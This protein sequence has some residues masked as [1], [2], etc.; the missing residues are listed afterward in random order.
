MA[1]S[2]FKMCNMMSLIKHNETGENLTSQD[3]SRI[4]RGAMLSVVNWP[5]E[6]SFTDNAQ[7]A[8]AF[9]PQPRHHHIGSP[10][11]SASRTPQPSAFRSA[12]SLPLTPTR[13]T[14]HVKILNFG[15]YKGKTYDT[16][17]RDASY[18]NWVL[19]ELTEDL[20][21]GRYFEDRRISER[22]G[23]AFIATKVIKLSDSEDA[24]TLKKAPLPQRMT[25]L[26]SWTPAATRLAMVN[27]G[28]KNMQQLLVTPWRTFP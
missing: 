26:R 10:P 20:H 27:F 17:Y 22:D 19:G 18:V 8:A 11:P 25:S 12:T 3:L 24:P 1:Q 28:F 2:V 15:R 9:S 6:S 21:L 5:P 14:R 4:L 23:F 16:A 13:D 7:N